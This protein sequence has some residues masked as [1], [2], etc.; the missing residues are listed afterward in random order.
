MGFIPSSKSTL[1]YRV[2]AF[3]VTSAFIAPILSLLIRDLDVFYL[4]KPA[5]IFIY[6]AVSALFSVLFFMCFH[7]GRG[8][9]GYL[10]VQDAAQIGKATFCAVISTTAF[11]LFFTGIDGLPRSISIIHFFVLI[12][13][14]SG[15]RLIQREMVQRRGFRNA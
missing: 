5:A 11:I 4:A 8:L 7:I 6:V 10:S 14:L 3:D 1:G 9:P 15:S 13:M 12:T 2:D